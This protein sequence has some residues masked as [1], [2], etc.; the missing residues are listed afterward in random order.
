VTVELAALVHKRHTT[1]ACENKGEPDVIL[2]VLYKVK[3]S[4]SGCYVRTFVA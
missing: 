3:E 4:L 2:G 1:T